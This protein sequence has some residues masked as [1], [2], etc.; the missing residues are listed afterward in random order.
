MAKKINKS[1]AMSLAAATCSLLG[2][3]PASP[4]NAQ[5]EKP[6]W[7]F[8]TSLLYYGESDDRVQDL[9]LN[10]LARRVFI[11][12]KSLTFT[13][14]VDSLT[15]ASASGATPMDVAQTFTSPSGKNTYTTP[16]DVLPLDDTFLD[17]RVAVN[18]TWQQPLG[19]LYNLSAGVSFSDEWD[20]THVGG[21]LSL[22]RD[23]N[24]RNT[25]LS[26]G[27]AFAQDSIDPEGGAPIP[28]AQMLDVGDFS[29]KMGDQDKD[30]VDVLLGVTQ[31]I[32]K[33]LL[34]QLNYSYSDSSGY[35]ND[36]YKIISIVDATTGDTLANVPAPGAEGP[37]HQFRFGSR[38]E[39]RVKHSAYG[40]AKYYWSGKVVDVSYRYMTDDWDIDSHTLDAKLRFP[41]GERSYLEPHVRYYTQTEAEFYTASIP[42]D[43]ALPL[44]ASSDFRLGDFDAITVGMKYGWK[45]QSGND[46]GVRLEY[47]MQSGDVPSA[48]IIG[49]QAQRNL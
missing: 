37:S 44:Y 17:T 41:I 13:L 22:S 32:N 18:A 16:A 3:A 8:N 20:Y 26:A 25:T 14:A 19:R 49:N 31:V 15:G 2:T 39:D 21:N 6:G 23:F 24:K 10:F 38:P 40:Q 48:Q 1:V 28:L 4:V 42:D 33:N 11:D 30:V 7:D 36:P 34:V 46:V 47:Y 45:T 43:I 5:E 29:N 35:L 12:D 27:L 9:S